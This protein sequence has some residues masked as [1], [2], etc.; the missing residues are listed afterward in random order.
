TRERHALNA[1]GRANKY[2]GEIR[3]GGS[4]ISQSIG[5]N[6]K[7]TF[8]KPSLSVSVGRDTAN[9]SAAFVNL[10][11]ANTSPPSFASFTRA[12]STSTPKTLPSGGTYEEYK[13]I[14]PCVARTGAPT[15]LALRNSQGAIVIAAAAATM[16]AALI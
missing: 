2:T 3:P 14:P 1:N 10:R 9:S 8:R 11:S 12:S 13:V 6:K 15:A 4:A 16:P 7:A 5:T